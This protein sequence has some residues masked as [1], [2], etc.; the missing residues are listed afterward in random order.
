[1]EETEAGSRVDAVRIPW[2]IQLYTRIHQNPATRPLEYNNS[3]QLTIMLASRGANCCSFCTA[4]AL[5]S[6][7]GLVG[8]AALRR[9]SKRPAAPSRPRPAGSAKTR[10]EGGPVHV[11]EGMK[12]MSDSDGEKER[13]GTRERTLASTASAAARPRG[14]QG[15]TSAR[16]MPSTRSGRHSAAGT[17]A[18]RAAAAGPRPPPGTASGGLVAGLRARGRGKRRRC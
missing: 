18:A 13:G 6:W 8:A 3:T 14:L 4:G 11:R 9:G 2:F 17:A 1:M 10:A 15:A 12:A 7:T 5:K 16:A